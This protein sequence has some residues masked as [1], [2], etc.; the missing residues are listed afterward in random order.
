MKNMGLGT[1]HSK[2]YWQHI[3]KKKKKPNANSTVLHVKWLRKI[4]NM[5]L[6]FEKD[7]KFSAEVDI[8]RT[9]SLWLV[10]CEGVD[11]VVS[12]VVLRVVMSG[13]CGMPLGELR[14][15]VDVWGVCRV[16]CTCVSVSWV[17][18]MGGNVKKQT[19]HCLCSH[20][21]QI[22]QLCCNKFSK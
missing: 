17:F 19:W 2:L 14:A 1:Q 6:C 4:V 10:G 18:L 20:C 5:A 3:K 13:V 15:L 21:S 8:R 11:R 22:H 9:G 12:E 7:L 16:V